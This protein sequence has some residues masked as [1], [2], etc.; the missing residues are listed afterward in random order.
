M[1]NINW[2]NCCLKGLVI[3]DVWLKKSPLKY[4]CVKSKEKYFIYVFKTNFLF[5][6]TELD[7]E[8]EREYD[9]FCYLLFWLHTHY[10]Y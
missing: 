2:V 8:K 5:L 7:P 6:A 4:I 10:G 9:L 3:L 1:V